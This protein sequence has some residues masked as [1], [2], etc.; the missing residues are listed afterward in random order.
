M[1]LLLALL[2]PLFAYGEN[3]LHLIDDNPKGFELYRSGKP[4]PQEMKEYCDLGITEMV[5]LS[6]T[7]HKYEDKM[8]HICPRLKVIYSEKQS[9]IVPLSA[10]F[11][12]SFDRWVMRAKKRGIKIIFRCSCGCHRTGRLAAYYQMKYQGLTSDDAIAVMDEHGK[13]MFLHP[14]LYPQVRAL[15]DYIFGRKCSQRW[16]YCVTRDLRQ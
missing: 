9:D 5:D 14:H 7:A 4:G 12:S 16:Y 2:F 15:E 6:G 8:S 3:N 1:T 11:L 13:H 10:E